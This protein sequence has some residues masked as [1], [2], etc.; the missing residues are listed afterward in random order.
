MTTEE[1]ISLY[2]GKVQYLSC[3]GI[4]RYETSRQK[5]YMALLHITT[6]WGSYNNNISSSIDPLH[7]QR[8]TG[9]G[10]SQD[11]LSGYKEY[12]WVLGVKITLEYIT[13]I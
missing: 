8:P 6:Q 11:T 1:N 4:Q 13:K 5:V 2:S 12:F 3:I 7:G 10:S 9:C